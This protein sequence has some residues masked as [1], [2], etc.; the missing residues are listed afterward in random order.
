MSTHLAPSGKTFQLT[1]SKFKLVNNA[2]RG[3]RR[4]V[5]NL[6]LKFNARFMVMEG[7]TQ[8]EAQPRAVHGS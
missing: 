4:V 2:C 5:D 6:L 7:P 8:R 1:S 3:V